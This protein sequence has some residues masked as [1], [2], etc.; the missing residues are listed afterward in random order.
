[1]PL[2]NRL[3]V[4]KRELNITEVK[5]T[6]RNRELYVRRR[7]AIYGNNKELAIE[8]RRLW[9]LRLQISETTYRESVFYMT[10]EF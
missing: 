5:K 6:H 8:K 7:E 10:S 4:K 9:F 1:M 3:H 2:Y